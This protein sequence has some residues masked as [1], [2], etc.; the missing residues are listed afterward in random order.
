MKAFLLLTQSKASPSHTRQ[1]RAWG[2]L[3]SKYY[4]PDSL[5][6]LKNGT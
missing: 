5:L 6:H 2:M 4:D 3:V 1:C